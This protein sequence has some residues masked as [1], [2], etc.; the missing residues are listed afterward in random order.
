MKLPGKC[1]VCDDWYMEVLRT[2]PSDH[3]LAGEPSKF[4]VFHD[5]A[6]RATLILMN[7]NQATVGLHEGCLAGF[8]LELPKF[9][10]RACERTRFIRKRWAGLGATRF[11]PEQ[12]AEADQYELELIHNPPLGILTHQ[13]PE[14]VKANA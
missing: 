13:K 14:K 7:G 8:A 2:F 6:I 4:G 3:V 9:W 11:T 12:N 5:N 1:P 10:K